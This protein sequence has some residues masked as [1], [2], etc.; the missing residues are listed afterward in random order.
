MYWWEIIGGLYGFLLFIILGFYLNKMRYLPRLDNVKGISKGSLVSIIVPVKDEEDTIEECLSSL[1]NIKYEP[2]EII[3]VLGESHDRTEEIVRKF[4]VKIVHEPPLPDGWVG[5]NWACYIGYKHAKGELLLFTDGDTIHSEDSLSRTVGV[6][7]NEGADMVTLFPKFVFRSFWEK[8]ITP[9]IAIFIGL[10][11][12]VWNLNDD[13]SKAFLGNGQYILIRR[14]TYEKIGG[15]QAVR[16]MII[17]DYALAGLIKRNGYKLRGYYAPQLLKVKMY[18]SF[19]ELWEGW[20][21]NIYSGIGDIKRTIIFI[22]I[23]SGLLLPYFFIIIVFSQLLNG[24]FSLLVLNLL[25]IL[26]LIIAG[27]IVYKDYDAEILVFLIPIAIFIIIML[28]FNSLIQ[29]TLLSVS[30]K[31]RKYHK[32]RSIK[33]FL[34]QIN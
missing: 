21:K 23:L 28:I 26:L 27:I 16:D 32:I 12:R 29:S 4:N 31:G 11:N 7:F 15:H 5:K 13:K 24:Y 30:W 20:S 25:P 2:K 14:M 34:N 17:E 9:L 1:I 19:N 33:K 22:L 18:H 3:V 8:L 6:V 10:T